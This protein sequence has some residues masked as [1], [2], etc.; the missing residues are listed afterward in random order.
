MD[1][2]GSSSSSTGLFVF[3]SAGCTTDS[4]FLA[5]RVGILIVH[6]GIGDYSMTSFVKAGADRWTLLPLLS[7]Q[8]QVAG[9][10]FFLSILP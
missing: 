2:A 7:M 3:E 1:R 5:D 4:L 9:H 8:L 6:V 10:L